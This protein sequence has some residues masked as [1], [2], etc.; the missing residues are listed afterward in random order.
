[1]Q[2]DEEG[3]TQEIDIFSHL[4]YIIFFDLYKYVTSVE[5]TLIGQHGSS[6][7]NIFIDASFPTSLTDI[8]TADPLQNAVHNDCGLFQPLSA[9]IR[10]LNPALDS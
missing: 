7:P 3:R 6:S 8:A 9:E 10:H 4:L 5:G 1:M 2:E